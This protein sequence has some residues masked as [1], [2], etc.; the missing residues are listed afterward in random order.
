MQGDTFSHKQH[1]CKTASPPSLFWTYFVLCWM[2]WDLYYAIK[3][4]GNLDATFVFTALNW[5]ACENSC[6]LFQ[7]NQEMRRWATIKKTLGDQNQSLKLCLCILSL[8]LSQHLL[9]SMIPAFLCCWW[10][11]LQAKLSRYVRRHFPSVLCF[12]E[13]TLPPVYIACMPLF[14]L[15]QVNKQ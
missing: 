8:H 6:S 7:Q 13:P 14:H 4:K 3:E 9:Q 11:Q 1:D 2:R 5:L 12:R 15:E 10:K